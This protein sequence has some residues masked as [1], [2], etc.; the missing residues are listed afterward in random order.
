[1]TLNQTISCVAFVVIATAA[2]CGYIESRSHYIYMNG[3][4]FDQ[5]GMMATKVEGQE[6]YLPIY[7]RAEQ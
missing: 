7:R 6:I 4:R 3:E 5:V 1:M 2:L